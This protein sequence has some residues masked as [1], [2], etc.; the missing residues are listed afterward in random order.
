MNRNI[1]K[2]LII[3]LALLLNQKITIAQV[4]TTNPA[5]PTDVDQ[6][7][8]TF[9]A[10]QATRKDLLNYTGDV[11]THTGVKIQGL[12]TWQYVKGT[13]ANNSTQ[14]KL[15][16]TGTNTYTLTISPSIRQYYGVLATQKITQLCFVF[17][18]TDATKQTEDIFYN[19]YEQG[20]TVGF[21]N[22]IQ[23]NPIFEY[24]SSI[25]VQVNSKNSTSL[26]LL[27]DN[28]EVSNTTQTSIT[29]NY[30]ATAYGKHWL[31]AIASDATETKK[32]SVYI[33]IR[34]EVT[35]EALPIGVV[36]GINKI[37][38]STVTLVLNDP[39]AK[40]QYCYLIGSFN[41]W[42]ID[43][44]YY[45]K[46]TPDGKYY[47]ITLTGLNPDQEYIYQYFV[48]GQI[49]LADPYCTKTSDPNDQYISQTNYPNL[50]NYPTGK[51]TGIASAFK[52]N[53]APYAWNNT[54]FTPPQKKDLVIYELH[55]RDFIS[56]DYIKTVKDSLHYL[57]KLGVNAIELMPISEFEGND[58]WGY[59][60]SFY[61]A[62]DKAYGT[63]NDYKAFI[64]ECH[65]R[66]IAVIQDIVLNHSYGQSPLVQMYFNTSTNKPTA[67]NPWYNQTS[68]NTSFS[69]GYDFNHESISTKAFVDSVLHYWLTEY[70]MDGFRFDF[71][72]GFT[73]VPG[74]GSAYD[75]SRIAILKRIADKIWN[76]NPNAYVILEHFCANTEEKELS[77]Y[78][79]M[80]WGNLN[81]NYNEATMGFV[82]TSDFSSVSY[83]TRG[84]TNPNLI[85]YMESHDEE[86]LMYK[87]KTYGN[88]T[89]TSYNI[90]NTSI[91][92]T[93]NE[94]AALFFFTVPGPKMIWQ[95]GE[96]GYDI[97][98]NY[99]NDRV[100]R[101]PIHWDYIQDVNRRH[102]LTTYA[103]LIKLKRDYPVFGTNDFTTSFSGAK[104]WIK[105]N[106][107]DMNA[108]AMGNF[109]VQNESFTLDFPNAGRWYE[110][111][112][113]DSIDLSTTSFTANFS[114]GEYR[115][116]T[117]K[118]IKKD[119]IF[120]EVEKNQTIISNSGFEVWPNPSN[121]I[122]KLGVNLINQHK[123]IVAI[124]SML[125]QQVFSSNYNNLSFGWNT[126]D[127]Q[128]PS[129]ITPGIYIC[130]ITQGNSI[131]SKKIIV[132]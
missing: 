16:R 100:G 88:A 94:L 65:K 59:N 131:Q 60:P 78:G 80:I 39:P 9:D 128:M 129:Y 116:Y 14:P 42:L 49:K 31:K 53:E 1:C 122:L 50:I 111:F 70:K 55:I 45:M 27:I 89:N 68:P 118:R 28:V 38:N 33:I 130:R 84:W 105:L 61:F 48:D 8:I 46:R 115:L 98:I 62:P 126:F 86:R 114:P 66:K 26:K 90:K 109:D 79:M 93:R 35:T 25:A 132:E 124:Y 23:N 2:V 40:K 127:I 102:L 110:Y 18:S 24:N 52:I 6:V 17:R 72:K 108:I 91:G 95:F 41:D 64:D 77:D 117:S 5:M 4:I 120:L 87:N 19:V 56:G 47:W 99:N 21:A 36:P 13:W 34:P 121:G 74:D 96:L 113:Q 32:D 101:K 67:D 29:Y 76:V 97:S 3:G 20:L 103:Q 43:G 37:D 125:G 58:S 92:L 104:K 106:S 12:T 75:A 7:V 51:T 107:N 81:Y 54:N 123:V 63:K 22:P 69:W 30:N 82:S 11:Y 85:G 10:S 44:Q 57:Q 15:T 73:N 112:A 119:D 71:T 83:K